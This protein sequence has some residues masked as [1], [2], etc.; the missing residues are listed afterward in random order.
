MVVEEKKKNILNQATQLYMV[1]ATVYKSHEDFGKKVGHWT[2]FP[3]VEKISELNV[4]W[5][6]FL[7]EITGLSVEKLIKLLS[8]YNSSQE[9]FIGYALRDSEPT[10]IHHFASNE[11]NS[12]VLYPHF[13][14]GFAMSLPLIQKIHSRLSED[15]EHAFS[16]DP[17]YEIAKFIWNN[18][19]GIQLQHSENF[20]IKNKEPHCVSWIEEGLPTCSAVV[21]TSKI[22]VAVKT[23]HKFHENRVKV[24]KST[25]APEV[26]NLHFFSDKNDHLIPTITLNVENVPNGHCEK[27]LSIMKYYLQMKDPLDWLIIVDD[28]TLLNYRRLLKLLS[29]YDSSISVALG[30]RYGYSV[31]NN[32]GY[33][34]ITGGGGMAFSLPAVTTLVKNCYC[35]SIDSPDDM[36]IGMCLKKLNIPVTHSHLF[37]QARPTDYSFDLLKPFKQISFHKHWM[38]DPYYVYSTWL[39]DNMTRYQHVEL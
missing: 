35:P 34:Y 30:E 5:V 7:D 26:E 17:K 24:I 16:I 2:I 27:T 18:G 14:P 29:C 32:L 8:T 25:W 10:I 1:N 19:M 31:T 13:A 38:I 9:H 23:C 39:K 3:L 11:G 37:H 33:D 36:I 15:F 4:D 12:A 21:S 20:C 22:F 28:D 6:F